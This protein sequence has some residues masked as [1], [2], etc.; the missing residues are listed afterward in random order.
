[1]FFKLLAIAAVGGIVWALFNKDK[2]SAI[3]DKT[4]VDEAVAEKFS[5]V[6]EAARY[7]S[8]KKSLDTLSKLVESESGQKALTTVR[9]EVANNMLKGDVS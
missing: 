6:S 2:V 7:A 8:A 3:L 9:K 4:T 1:M 5:G